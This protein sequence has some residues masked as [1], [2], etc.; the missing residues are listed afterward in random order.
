MNRRRRRIPMWI[1]IGFSAWVAVLIPVY[2]HH[3]G[4]ANYLWFSDVALFGGLIAC[5]MEHRLLASMMAVLV[6]VPEGLWMAEFVVQLTTGWSITG[7]TNY[8]FDQDRPIYLRALSLFHLWLPPLLVWQVLRLH[9]APRALWSTVVLGVCVLILTY[10]LSDPARN[11]NWAFGLGNEPQTLMPPMLYLVLLMI[12]F[13]VLVWLPGHLLL[14][15]LSSQM[16][17]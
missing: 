9:Y 15:W 14:R 13:T 4:P 2:Y 3:Y 1:K 5:W 17:A 6:L 10:L 12:G 8:M 7:M 16:E 11:I